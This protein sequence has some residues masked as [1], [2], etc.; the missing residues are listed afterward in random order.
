MVITIIFDKRDLMKID[1][2]VEEALYRKGIEL[3]KVKMGK[4]VY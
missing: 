2:I 3:E 1:N 4:V